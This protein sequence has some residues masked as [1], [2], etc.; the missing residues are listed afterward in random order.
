MARLESG[1]LALVEYPSTVLTRDD[2]GK[3]LSFEELKKTKL[4]EMC[5]WKQKDVKGM[6]KNVY[7]KEV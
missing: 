1:P 2:Y 4:E 6:K 5:H 7:I 3:R